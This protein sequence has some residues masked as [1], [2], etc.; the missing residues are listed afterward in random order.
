MKNKV[1]FVLN[2]NNGFTKLD[3]NIKA[4]VSNVKKFLLENKDDSD[5]Y[6][7]NDLYTNLDMEFETNKNLYYC[8]EN[9]DE[10]NIDS[11]LLEFVNL[12]N[13]FQKN[14]TNAFWDL[15]PNLYLKYNE[16]TLV[17]A[18][19]DL[20]ILEFA[21]TL[22]TYLLK[23]KLKKNIVVYSDLV[24]TFDNEN[25]SYKKYQEL[26]LKLLSQKGILVKKHG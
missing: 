12:Q 5:I 26:S 23:L 10:S 6:F 15:D 19:T 22:K 3:E 21:L 25:H 20:D 2:L 4:I 17:G 11:S 16:F 1:I 18:C 13:K 14:S 9:T 24:A 8:N 7:V